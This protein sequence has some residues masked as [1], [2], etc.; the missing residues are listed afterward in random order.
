M[1][2]EEFVSASQ[3]ERVTHTHGGH[4]LELL[5]ALRGDF[6]THRAP[7]HILETRMNSK[8]YSNGAIASN[9]R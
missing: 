5:T 3:L 6:E 4:S 1:K 7:L 8:P 2:L 9:M